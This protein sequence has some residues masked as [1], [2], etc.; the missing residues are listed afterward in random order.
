MRRIYRLFLD[1]GLRQGEIAEQ[2]NAEG[3]PGE[4]G[5]AWNTWTIGQVLSN[6]KYAG[7]YRFGRSRRGLDGRRRYPDPDQHQLTCEALEPIVP[8]ARIAAANAKRDRR[9]LFLSRDEMLMRLKALAARDGGVTIATI[10]AAPSLPSPHTV[11]RHLGSLWTLNARVGCYPTRA[12]RNVPLTILPGRIDGPDATRHGASS[13]N[14]KTSMTSNLVASCTAFVGDKMIAS[15][16][17]VDVALALKAA[18]AD[19]SGPMPL[20]FND[21]TGEVLELDL[22]GAER[23][24]V[25]R[26]QPEPKE[27]PRPARGRPKLGVTAREVTLMPKHWEWLSKQPGGASAALRR[28]VEAAAKISEA[29]DTKRAL[30]DRVYKVMYAL[31]GHLPGY[32]EASRKLFAGDL[33]E[34]EV[35]TKAWPV[36]IKAYVLGLA[37]SGS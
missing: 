30:T 3:E 25:A 10:S 19:V 17:P 9:M 20:V 14:R 26:L 24:I 35:A 18:G 32:E 37:Q 4:G 7:V 16:A 8:L 13:G 22:R 6:P 34:L 21:A 11:T 2:L 27:P 15:G 5:R 1:D 31:A 33:K 23:D 28:L 12:G 29:N 36:D